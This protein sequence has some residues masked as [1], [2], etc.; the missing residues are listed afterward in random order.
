MPA[1]G[2]S[3]SS[4]PSLK[5]ME[6]VR[7]SLDRCEGDDIDRKCVCVCVGGGGYG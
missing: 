2:Y 7:H 1:N 5:G 3:I 4:Q 6:S